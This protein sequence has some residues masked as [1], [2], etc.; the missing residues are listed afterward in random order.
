MVGLIKKRKKL[1][2]DV[3]IGGITFILLKLKKRDQA[4]EI[5]NLV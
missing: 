4:W 3:G 1:N 2:K 5:F